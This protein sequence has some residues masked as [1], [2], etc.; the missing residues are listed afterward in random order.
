V[1]EWFRTA[2]LTVQR[3]LAGYDPLAHGV[4]R[5]FGD[6]GQAPVFIVGA[7]RTGSTLLFQ[8]L[9]KHFQ[10]AYISNLM[11]AAPRAMIRLARA[12]SSRMRRAR[13]IRE[14]D[15]GYTPGLLSP[16]EAGAVMNA[17]FREDAESCERRL[18]RNSVALI[19][20]I[21]GGALVTKNLANS[22]RLPRIAEI[23]PEARFIHIRR[24]PLLTAQSLLLARRRHYGSDREWL[25]IEPP[26]ANEVREKPPSYQVV[27]QATTIDRR[28]CEF[29]AASSACALVVRYEDLCAQPAEQLDRIQ[30]TFGL[31]PRRGPA[32]HA[33]SPREGVQLGELE[34]SELA[35]W[36]RELDAAPDTAGP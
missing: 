1:N 21:L 19:S 2:A 34:W 24:D 25:S 18:V 29:L 23:F 4:E 11:A 3:S 32:P 15:L 31:T 10:V 35:G 6:T 28:V 33:L 27:W 22:L 7:P 30:Q 16:N 13:A 26:G 9:V 12:T 8:L 17:W 5:E 14:S 20:E 36:Q